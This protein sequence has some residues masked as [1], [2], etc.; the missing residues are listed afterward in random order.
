MKI[1]VLTD[2]EN[3]AYHSIA[4]SLV[5]YN[6]YTHVHISIMHIKSDISLIR[7]NF[8]KYDRILVM[9][10]QNYEK[11]NFIPHDRTMTGVHSFHSWDNKKTTPDKDVCPPKSLVHLL[12][13]FTKV[14]VVSKRLYEVFTKA[15]VNVIY[16][17][18][19]VDSEIFLRRRMPPVGKKTI[20]G[21]SGSKAHDWRK[22][23]SQFILPAVKRSNVEV[24]IAMLSTNKYVPLEKMDAFYNDVD[25]YVCASLS[26]GMSLSVLEAASCG[27]PVIT[28]RVSGSTEIIKDGITGFFVDRDVV[29]ISNKINEL[30]VSDRL[31][32]MSNNIYI[33]IRENWCWSVKAKAWLDYMI[34]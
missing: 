20:I 13:S 1:L 24:K 4:K 25:C 26:E 3:W 6:P 16:T 18:N 7:K 14:N 19:G 12:N 21:Y 11:V 27:R 33:D 22:G 2:R 29:D 17:P 15:G 30:K 10:W 8:N 34:G 28:T 23:V 9:G 5:K 31:V 32:E